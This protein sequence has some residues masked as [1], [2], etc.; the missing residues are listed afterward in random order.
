MYGQEDSPLKERRKLNGRFPTFVPTAEMS[1]SGW[2]R[3]WLFLRMTSWIESNDLQAEREW[4]FFSRS[5]LLAK[6]RHKACMLGKEA[7]VSGRCSLG[8]ETYNS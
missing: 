2:G 8:V 6:H 5:L 7:S 3:Q 1:T 4:G